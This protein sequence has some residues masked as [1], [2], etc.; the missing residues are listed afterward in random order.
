MIL[1]GSVKECVQALAQ[2]GAAAKL[3]AGGTDLCPSSRTTC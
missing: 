3:V 2:H 1:P